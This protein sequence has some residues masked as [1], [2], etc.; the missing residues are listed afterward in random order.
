MKVTL[1]M[2][3]AFR[4]ALKETTVW[5]ISSQIWYLLAAIQ[6][7]SHTIEVSG[8][9]FDEFIKF[10]EFVNRLLV[11]QTL[12]MVFIVMIGNKRLPVVKL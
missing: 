11:V 5:I 7:L 6:Q 3:V 8:F 4:N 10:D 2:V 9:R 1:N 12:Q